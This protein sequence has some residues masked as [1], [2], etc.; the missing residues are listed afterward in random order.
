MP[1]LHGLGKLDLGRAGNRTPVLRVQLPLLP[2]PRNY[3]FPAGKILTAEANRQ[4][5]H[6]S[7]VVNAMHSVRYGTND[8]EQATFRGH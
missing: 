1:L 3:F 2:E 7:P 6:K 4:I 8:K 5:K